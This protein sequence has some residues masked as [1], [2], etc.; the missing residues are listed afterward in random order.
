[1]AGMISV[2]YVKHVVHQRQHWPW[3]CTLLTAAME[4]E[5][6]RILQFLRTPQSSQASK[7]RLQ[8]L[9]QAGFTMPEEWFLFRPEMQSALLATIA[10]DPQTTQLG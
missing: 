5:P 8:Q 10:N 2:V 3:T 9:R 6:E 7:Q 1:M 4:F